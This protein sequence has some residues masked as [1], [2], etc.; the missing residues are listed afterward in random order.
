MFT[1]SVCSP[2]FVC[3]KTAAAKTAEIQKSKHSY[4]RTITD[5]YGAAAAITTR[6]VPELG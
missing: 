1:T 5:N 2:S 3:L 6:I 4:C